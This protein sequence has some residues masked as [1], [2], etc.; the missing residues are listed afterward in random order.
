MNT[1]RIGI[2]CNKSKKQCDDTVRKLSLAIERE[3]AVPLLGDDT[4]V[5][6]NAD[7]LVS[8]GGDGTFLKVASH[9]L[10]RDIPVIGINLGTLGFLTEIEK[11]DIDET[12]RRLVRKDYIVEERKVMKV[13]VER[14]NNEVFSCH[15]I[16]DCVIARE[17]LS[18][19]LYLDVY[20][21]RHY[22][23]TYP[24]D[25]VILSTQTGS[26]AYCLSA[27]GPI[28]EPG[29]ELMVLTPLNAHMVEGRPIILSKSSV[30]EVKLHKEHEN[31]HVICD[32]HLSYRLEKDDVV[33]CCLVDR[34]I[35]II[36]MDPPDFYSVLRKKNA[37]RQTKN[38]ND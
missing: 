1:I 37:E 35:K 26:T 7:M 30:I 4:Y 12:V 31:A 8:I 11:H 2:I 25:G 18:K 9:A 33:K 23:D 34:H 10:K 38:G 27:G 22:V 24:G 19:V 36:R 29:N 15:A 14:E 21:N 16:N 20:A 17:I 13:T 5:Y 3:G 28:V 32:G 6:E